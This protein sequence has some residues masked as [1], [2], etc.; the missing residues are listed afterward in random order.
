MI[1]EGDSFAYPP[2]G[3]TREEA[4]RYVGIGVTKFDELVAERRMPRPKR[5]GGRVVWDR[6][7]IDA[8]FTDLPD[9]KPGLE[10]QLEASGKRRN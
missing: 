7:Q 1:K 10:G 8:Y 6:Y 3:L 4:A 9:Q 5:V 2:R